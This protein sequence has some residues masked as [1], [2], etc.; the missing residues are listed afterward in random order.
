MMSEV[1]QA[2]TSVSEK[3]A[4]K[5][6]TPE[7]KERVRLAVQK[8]RR[9]QKM[10]D[11]NI[12][13]DGPEISKR[14]AKKIL[15]EERGIKNPRVLEVCLE[16]A[17]VA[18]R[19]LKLVSNQHLFRH[20]V[21]KTLQANKNGESPSPLDIENVWQPGSPIRL[22]EQ[23]ALYDF[24][25]AWRTQPDGHQISF[26]EFR[27]LRQLCIE[28]V[29][30]F[31]NKILGLDFH[32]EPHGKWSTDLFVQK[33]YILSEHYT[34]EE[35]KKALDAL[36]PIHQ[37]LLI[38]ARNSYKSSYNLVDMLSWCLA[39]NGDIRIR[40]YSSTQ[41]LSRG[42]I[43]KFRSYWTLKNSNEPT[44]FN[45]LWP[46]HMI[47]PDEGASSSYISPMR[48]LDLIQPTL[49]SASIISEGDAGERADLLVLEDVAEISNSSNQEM[50]AKTQMRVDMLCELLEPTGYLQVIGT[51]ISPG[52]GTEDDP[53]DVYSVLLAREAQRE[54]PRM[55]HTICPCWT[56]N[57]GVNKLP[58]DSTL[59]ADEVTLL[60]PSRLTFKLLMGKLRD[61]VKIFR[62][63]SLCSW[64]PDDE[65]EIKLNFDQIT[66]QAACVPATAIPEGD[67]VASCDQAYSLSSRA[68][69]TSIAICKLHSNQR[70]EKCL[71]V[72]D[73]IADRFRQSEL[74]F[75][76]VKIVRKYPNIR[77]ILIERGPTA[78]NL[79]QQ[80]AMAGAKYG[81]SIPVY[82]VNPSTQ[83]AA[84][85]LR[86]R[87]LEILINLGRLKFCNGE[88]LNALF[89]EL[90]KLD[91]SVP[92]T[93]RR[94]DRADSIAQ[95]AS[96]FKVYTE[97]IPGEKNSDEE[98]SELEKMQRQAQA[99]AQYNQMFESVQ[100]QPPPRQE[101][102]P[103]PRRD[104][105]LGIFGNGQGWRM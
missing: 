28:N 76:F 101:E 81:V 29:Y 58:Y 13:Y 66:L 5:V 96:F 95:A 17:E 74:A 42:F 44:L 99:R 36:S 93:R 85:F 62:Q 34:Q 16:L 18:C 7:E 22:P 48:L 40:M 1:E 90:Q 70:H 38:S 102:T 37:R 30:E 31:G 20:G 80:I 46:E 91:G 84:K 73:V 33:K 52:L 89:A 41:P 69:L 15:E 57:E 103:A 82:F 86:I 51:P 75:E 65:A 26:D 45:Q 87:D 32:P 2:A 19:N 27:Q 98:Q 25:T 35:V 9:K 21:V 12:A 24:S 54:E 92:S 49:S 97:Q 64:V 55:L 78:E 4:K 77:T 59:T 10:S 3:P 79:Q 67:I 104:I 83:K 47:A 56:V 88:Y 60:F 72:L 94:D 11:A 39:F 63:Q 43:R 71:A 23:Y 14:D 8:T 68:D 50:R 61:N 6:R 105:R 53:G 100:K